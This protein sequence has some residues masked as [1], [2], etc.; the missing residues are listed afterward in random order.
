MSVRLKASS[1]KEE[2]FLKLS[3]LN[4]ESGGKD[5]HNTR[6]KT[7]NWSTSLWNR[8]NKSDDRERNCR[9]MYKYLF[10]ILKF[11]LLKTC[12]LFLISLWLTAR[13]NNTL[14]KNVHKDSQH[15]HSLLISMSL[16]NRFFTGQ[17]V[18]QHFKIYTAL[19][20]FFLLF[21]LS[22]FCFCRWFCCFFI[23][24]IIHQIMK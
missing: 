13:R 9:K 5:C 21:P 22:L 14:R 3:W 19:L 11:H 1:F 17:S 18:H 23:V 16:I 6:E 7:A 15:L 24:L 10:F 20:L 2:C 8:K 12:G 4:E